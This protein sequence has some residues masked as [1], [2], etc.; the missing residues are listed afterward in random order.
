MDSN[1][2]FGKTAAAIAGLCGGLSIS[3]FYQPQKLHAHGKLAA[4][5][6][7]G[8]IAVSSAFALGGLVAK[9]LGLSL[10][11]IDVSL[12]IGYFV[13]MLSVG[14]ISWVANF[15]EKREGK[16]ILEVANEIR[17]SGQNHD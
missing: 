1:F 3:L 8:G 9:T 7:I 6:I 17:S 11:D 5:A 16:D 12:G 15:L 14:L 4:G 13:G 2:L 10:E